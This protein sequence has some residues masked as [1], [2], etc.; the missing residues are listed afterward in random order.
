MST[1][2]LQPE[3]LRMFMTAAEIKAKYRPGD[4]PKEAP[5]ADRFPLTPQQESNR[6]SEFWQFK[7]RDAEFRHPVWVLGET[8]RESIQAEGVKEPVEVYYPDKGEPYISEGHHRVAVAAADRPKDYLPV[9]YRHA[10][11][12]FPWGGVDSSPPDW[13]TRLHQL[14]FSERY[15]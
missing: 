4:L 14:S 3:Q 11:S 2:A 13:S 12:S 8:L 7:L 15:S 1:D 6:V 5:Y 9:T 10:R